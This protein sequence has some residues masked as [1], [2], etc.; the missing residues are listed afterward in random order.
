MT[1]KEATWLIKKTTKG[2]TVKLNMNLSGQTIECANV[3]DKDLN[4]AQCKYESKHNFE[5][6]FRGIYVWV[7]PSGNVMYSMC[8]RGLKGNV[9]YSCDLEDLEIVK[10]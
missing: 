9:I 3:T 4:D 7:N 2:E 6:P 1:T 10:K 5:N 8:V